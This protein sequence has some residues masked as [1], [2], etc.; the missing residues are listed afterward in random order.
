MSRPRQV[1]PKASGKQDPVA[2]TLIILIAAV[3]AIGV[4]WVVQERRSL[5]TQDS[6]RR[7]EKVSASDR[8]DAESRRSY[9]PLN[10]WKRWCVTV[11]VAMCPACSGDGKVAAETCRTCSGGGLK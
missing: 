5:R 7:L 10:E 9:M 1:T 2:L 6:I 3:V 8:Q 11:G 4:V